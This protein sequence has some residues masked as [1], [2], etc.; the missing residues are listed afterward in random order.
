MEP[1]TPPPSLPTTCLRARRLANSNSNSN[2]TT[3]PAHTLSP[4]ATKPSTQLHCNSSLSADLMSRTP[5]RG[6]ARTRTS[7]HPM[8]S[9][10][11]AHQVKMPLRPRMFTSP[12]AAYPQTPIHEDE[13]LFPMSP[14]KT[15]A[16]ASL[17]TDG[18]VDA[19]AG[20]VFGE[21]MKVLAAMW[22]G[23]DRLGVR[24]RPR[25]RGRTRARTRPANS[26]PGPGFAC[27]Q[28]LQHIVVPPIAPQSIPIKGST[29]KQD[30]DDTVCPILAEPSVAPPSSD[31]S[32][33]QPFMYSFPVFES[34]PL[35][36]A[37]DWR[38]RRLAT[39]GNP[40]MRPQKSASG[41]DLLRGSISARNT[42][43]E[44]DHYQNDVDEDDAFVSS[45]FRS[46]SLDDNTGS[47]DGSHA[48]AF[49]GHL[50][51]ENPLVLSGS[52]LSSFPMLPAHSTHVTTDDGPPRVR[53][54]PATDSHLTSTDDA[55]KLHKRS[56]AQ[57]SPVLDAKEA[58]LRRGRALIP[59]ARMEELRAAAEHA[60]CHDRIPAL[61]TREE[62]D[63]EDEKLAGRFDDLALQRSTME[64]GRAQRPQMG[65]W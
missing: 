41:S 26:A 34:S 64:R 52:L 4:T 61:L 25:T 15:N 3:F 7:M 13:M 29:V 11:L 51:H 27:F 65:G 8:L 38:E 59:A 22:K 30:V 42:R 2:K 35:M 60:G 14:V 36:R 54:Q 1:L 47:G 24:A 56:S 10:P 31:V 62:F 58:E 20:V 5:S 57:R 49:S 19:G 46:H 39:N 21:N 23:H 43:K 37:K 48:L 50:Q 45:A 18:A 40:G 16:H 6:R 32:A 63:S 17:F 44:Y 9:L 53:F 55:T 28:E 33:A 12:A